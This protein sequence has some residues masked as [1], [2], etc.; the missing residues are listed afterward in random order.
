MWQWSIAKFKSGWDAVMGVRRFFQELKQKR[1]ATHDEE[2]LP[3]V[4]RWMDETERKVRKEKNLHSY[5]DIFYD[6]EWW[7]QTALPGVSRTLIRKAIEK[8]QEKK[9]RIDELWNKR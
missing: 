2:K 4:I 6:E 8:R 7:I 1:D 3:Q 9:K 5:V